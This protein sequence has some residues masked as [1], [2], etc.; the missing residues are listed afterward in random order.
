MK[1]DFSF[2]WDEACQKALEDIM[3]YLTKSLVLVAPISGKSF[4]LYV[5]VMD[6]SL[7]TLIAQKNDEGGE[8]PIYYQSKTLIGAESRYNPVEKECL[9]FIFA[10]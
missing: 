4:L 2:I 6:H 1:K 5:L 10:V 9:S 8:Q 3:E 7:N